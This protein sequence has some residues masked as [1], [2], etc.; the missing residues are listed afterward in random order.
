MKRY[1]L[2]AE[3]VRWKTTDRSESELDSMTYV[4]ELESDEE[5][6]TRLDTLVIER[7]SSKPGWSYMLLT[8]G[9][10]EFSGESSTTTNFDLSLSTIYTPDLDIAESTNPEFTAEIP[11]VPEEL[12]IQ[13]QPEGEAIHAPDQENPEI[14]KDPDQLQ[15]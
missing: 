5:A 14:N 11:L 6:K 12:L 4:M 13:N 7:M 9:Y 3:F 8:S 15:V 2:N 10:S 1:L